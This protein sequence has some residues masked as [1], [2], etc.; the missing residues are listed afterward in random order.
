MKEETKSWMQ[1]LLNQMP[2]TKGS[3]WNDMLASRKTSTLQKPKKDPH[4]VRER[5]VE[6]ENNTRVEETI[7]IEV[8]KVQLDTEKERKNLELA[9]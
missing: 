3:Y 6:S 5:K 2:E 8:N 1:N 9:M 7:K 4:K